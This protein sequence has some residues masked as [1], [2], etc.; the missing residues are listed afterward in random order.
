MALGPGLTTYNVFTAADRTLHRVR[1]QL[2]GQVITERSMRVFEPTMIDQVNIFARNLLLESQRSNPVNMTTHT[3]KLGLDIAGL[4]GFGYD[5]RLQTNEENQFMRTVLD[6][7]TFASSVLLQYPPLKKLRL[8]F[9]LMWSLR[10]LREKYLGLMETMITSRTTQPKDA[11]HDLYSFVADVLDAES[12]GLR[13]SDL[14]AEANL[15]LSA[16]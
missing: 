2:I 10:N 8:G 7:G 1:R 15:F 3:R 16:G 14:W 6:G 11:K 12:G 13:Q 9:L 4:L 5:L